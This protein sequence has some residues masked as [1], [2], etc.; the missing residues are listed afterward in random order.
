MRLL[1]LT[2]TTFLTLSAAGVAHAGNVL[3]VG[4]GQQ[5]A[6]P[7]AA[8]AAAQP[9]DEVDVTAGSYTDSCEINTKGLIVKGVGGRP[10]IDLS[11]TN[12]PADYKGIY[13]VQA[14]DVR[15]EN[16][17]LTGAHIDGAQGENGAGIRI[18]ANGLV[19]HGC[20]I[21]DN[22]N[23]I[24][25]N[26]PTAGAGTLTIENSELAHN[27]LGNG[28]T[29]GNGCTHNLYAGNFGKLIFQYNW[30][31][32]I[33]QDGHLLKSRAAEND[34]SY[35]RITGE[36]GG[37]SYSINLPNG[38][39]AVVV[40]NVIQKGT[41][42]NNSI[43]LQYGEEGLS[44]SDHRLFVVNNTFVNERG[45]GTFINLA[46]GGTLTAHD[47]LLVGMGTPANSGA[48]SADNL[49]FATS[50]DA[51][52][53]DAA[54]YDYHLAAGSPA[55]GKTVD[56]GMADTRSLTP[57]QEYVQPLAGVPRASAHDV[58]AFEYGNSVDV[59]DAGV[60]PMP[61]AGV[62]DGVDAAMGN[63]APQTMSPKSGCS[64]AAGGD[65][66]AGSAL[67]LLGIAVFLALAARRRRSCR[68][69]R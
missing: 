52:L 14:D 50:S 53:V 65:A 45:G 13:V 37:D 19:V 6:T 9:N 12:H 31:H 47:N 57:T 64:F 43:L 20:Y 36:D 11:G 62:A 24:L 25:G 17:E 29:D 67:A 32:T 54:H 7:C 66:A 58:G 21:H 5:Y 35:N 18:Q 1:R 61:D 16:L 39:L 68:D 38:G 51:M 22:Q 63:D 33:G 26:P 30:T 40:G 41:K 49:L 28:C 27:G 2:A 56:P 3:L 10:K 69:A 55:R 46:A 4:P 48:L 8:I 23:G 34:I 15:L 42:A 59:P 60:T 44:N